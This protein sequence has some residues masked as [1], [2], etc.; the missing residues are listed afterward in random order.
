MS[1][2][3]IIQLVPEKEACKK[4]QIPFSLFEDPYY[5]ERSDYG[6]EPVKYKEVIDRIAKELRP[7]AFVNKKKRTLTFKSKRSV[8]EYF[9]RSVRRTVRELHKTLRTGQGNIGSHY[10]LRAALE[11]VCGC[12]D[13]FWLFYARPLSDILMDYLNGYIPR[14]VWFGEILNAHF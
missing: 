13:I 3:K 1:H 9:L 12:E 10:R 4:A 14:T 7:V 8:R 2:F 6:G 11:D 5:L